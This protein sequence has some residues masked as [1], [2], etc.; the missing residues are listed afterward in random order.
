MAL[1][2]D[3]LMLRPPTWRVFVHELTHTFHLGDEYV[4]RADTYTGPDT[5]FDQV[6]NLMTEAG[7]RL[8]GEP[9]KIS[10]LLIKWNWHR[11]RK[12]SVIRLPIDDRLANG[13]SACSSAR[14]PVSSSRSETS[15]SCASARAA[16]SSSAIR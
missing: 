13:N 6:P 1:P 15:C 3:T 11:I 14:E 12:A 7:A 2:T 9:Q 5:D 4:E 10:F 16:R 8:E